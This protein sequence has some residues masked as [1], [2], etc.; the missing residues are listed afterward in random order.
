MSIVKLILQL[1]L[2]LGFGLLF[3]IDVKLCYN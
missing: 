2:T 1:D 3:K